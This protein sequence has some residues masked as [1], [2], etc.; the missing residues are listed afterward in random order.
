M[1]T[2]KEDGK[3]CAT[4]VFIGGLEIRT[5]FYPYSVT[6]CSAGQHVCCWTCSIRHQE[7]LIDF[8]ITK[9]YNFSLKEELN[10]SKIF[11]CRILGFSVSVICLLGSH[12]QFPVQK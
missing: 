6:T 1:E 3:N 7:R 4:V 2:Y 5:H 11:V 8:I 10:L 12:N 9:N